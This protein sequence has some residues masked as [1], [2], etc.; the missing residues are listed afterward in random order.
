MY[1]S[2]WLTVSKWPRRRDT[3]HD[4]HVFCFFTG[5]GQKKLLAFTCNNKRRTRRDRCTYGTYGQIC[6]ALSGFTLQQRRAV[7][8]GAKEASAPWLKPRTTYKYKYSNSN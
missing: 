7:T 8:G 6:V 2:I 5:G 1:H 3:E 4:M